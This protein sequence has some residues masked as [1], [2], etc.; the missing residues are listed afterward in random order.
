MRRR[1]PRKSK[2]QAPEETRQVVI[3][4][5]GARGDGISR[6]EDGPIYVPGTAPGDGVEIKIIGAKADGRSGRV[7]RLI[8]PGPDRVTPPCRHADACGGCAVQHLADSAVARFKRGVLVDALSR[9]ALP[10]D[11]VRDTKTVPPATRRR[12]NLAARRTAA[13]AVLGFNERGGSRIIDLAECKVATPAVQALFAPLRALV[14]KLDSVS[15]ADIL[16]TETDTGIDALI[17]PADGASPGLEEREILAEFAEAHDLARLAWRADGFLE[18]LAA[19][20]A[21]EVSFGG[22]S[23]ELPIGAFL[24]PSLIGQELLIGLVSEGLPTATGR[25]ADLYAG[26]GA[27]TLPLAKRGVTVH[28]AEGDAAAVRALRRAGAGLSLTAE[29]RD[30]ARAP[31]PIEALN[32]FDAVIFDPPRAGAGPQAEQLAGSAVGSVVA[33]SCN[34]A[35]LARDLR[36][37]VDGGYTMETVTPVDQFTWSAHVEAV[38]I[39]RRL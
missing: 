21:P 2:P 22:V 5:L 27:F 3:D 20:R 31:L 39:L 25:V 38:A 32:A 11:Q 16:I 30:L 9:K 37:L 17:A 35:T 14:A 4:A 8:S 34:P 13:G 7:T 6:A 12:M 33:V 19:R 29:A 36:I 18:P 1:N 15:A 23:V 28:A 10:I 26:C 24:Q